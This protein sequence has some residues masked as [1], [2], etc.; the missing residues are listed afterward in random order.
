MLPLPGAFPSLQHLTLRSLPEKRTPPR[1]HT[2][3]SGPNSKNPK[4]VEKCTVSFVARHRG[5]LHKAAFCFYTLEIRAWFLSFCHFPPSLCHSVFLAHTLKFKASLLLP[6][7]PFFFY[8]IL[9]EIYICTSCHSI[10]LP[11]PQVIIVSGVQ[12]CLLTSIKGRGRLGAGL[13]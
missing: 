11:H 10:L 9:S 4:D 8:Y 5:M 6:L 13:F 7:L 2:P 12:I 1:K 3:Y